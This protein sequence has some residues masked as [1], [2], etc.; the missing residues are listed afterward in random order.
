MRPWDRA[1][2][3]RRLGATLQLAIDA[4]ATF[5]PGRS[6]SLAGDGESERQRVSLTEKVVAETALLL[7][8][9]APLR[10]SSAVQP[11]YDTLVEMV[12]P[13]ARSEILLAGICLDAGRAYEYATAHII[14]SHLGHGDT[15]VDELISASLSL[16]PQFGPERLPYRR[17]EQQWLERLWRLRD[18]TLAGE[19]DLVAQSMIGRSLDVL[20]ANR[21]DIYALTH[22]VMYGTDFGT[23]RIRMPRPRQA[24]AADADAALACSLD[25]GDW[26]L[27]AEL[28]LTQPILGVAWSP[29]M[30]FAFSIVAAVHDDLGFL[31]GSAFDPVTYA[32]LPSVERAELAIRTSYHTSY[33]MGFV[34]ALAL[35]S[36]CAPPSCL[37][38]S[39]GDAAESLADLIGPPPGEQR[40]RDAFDALPREQRE[41]IAPLVRD[42]ALRRAA[43]TGDVRRLRCVLDVADTHDL[44]D[45]PAP[46]QAA[47]LLHRTLALG[48]AT[49]GG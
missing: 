24:I 23:R 18:T 43:S 27:T 47:A 33:V 44:V 11:Q 41:A 1:D 29:A 16:G 35:T 13:L 6:P 34:C 36:G 45:A 32:T 10:S 39:D 3:L 15:A 28:L 14:L 21:M 2:L 42:I 19:A 48:T 26:D 17:L 4:I 9:S 22:A 20:A 5:D 49:R 38:A 8:L 7:L 25:A 37:P 40:W 12:S 30:T 46:R 31:P